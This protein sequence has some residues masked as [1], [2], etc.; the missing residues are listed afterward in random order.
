MGRIWF[1]NFQLSNSHYCLISILWK[2][3]MSLHSN[4]AFRN[5]KC[6][7]IPIMT[8]KHLSDNQKTPDFFF[9]IL[10]CGKNAYLCRFRRQQC[11]LVFRQ[12]LEYSAIVIT[13]TSTVY[14]VTAFQAQNSAL[15]SCARGS[16]SREL[17]RTKWLVLEFFVQKLFQ[18]N[19]NSRYQEVKKLKI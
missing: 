6:R 3:T 9:F 10:G 13:F 7:Y 5:L 11:L 17:K 2:I 16:K 19:L 12:D 18:T 8:C 15:R 14:R 1:L 4:L